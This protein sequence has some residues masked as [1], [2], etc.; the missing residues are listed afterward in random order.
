MVDKY[1]IKQR[2]PTDVGGTDK[3]CDVAVSAEPQ[4][5]DSTSNVYI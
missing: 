4:N 1:D 3:Q 2:K 5:T